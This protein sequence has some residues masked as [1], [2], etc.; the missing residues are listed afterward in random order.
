MS[1]IKPVIDV[2]ASLPKDI[3]NS[4]DT[5][6][7]NSRFEEKEKF[8]ANL[9]IVNVNSKA[10]IP[11]SPLYVPGAA[12]G[13][14]IYSEDRSHSHKSVRIIPLLAYE[15]VCEYLA[16]P[17]GRKSQEYRGTRF[18]VGEVYKKYPEKNKAGKTVLP[19]GHVLDRQMKIHARLIVD[20]EAPYEE[21]FRPVVIT[22]R[23][24]EVAKKRGA[25]QFMRD[26]MKE[27]QGDSL[28]VNSLTVTA[29][30]ESI[31]DK[32]MSKFFSFEKDKSIVDFKDFMPLKNALRESYQECVDKLAKDMQKSLDIIKERGF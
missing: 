7:G 3:K 4:L 32:A 9:S 1:K 10:L 26:Y 8:P 24:P 30:L 17:D 12:P 13:D 31:F 11:S 28:Y 22:L 25:I 14:I 15:Q 18:D 21:G 19:N 20:E 29:A 6:P 27:Y 16:E 23:G 2:L 5:A